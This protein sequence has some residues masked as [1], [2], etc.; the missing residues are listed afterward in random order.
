MMRA[1]SEQ[2]LDSGQPRKDGTLSTPVSTNGHHDLQTEPTEDF[3]GSL[4]WVCRV[5][6]RAAQNRLHGCMGTTPGV[7]Q[8][9]K[10]GTP[11]PIV[12]KSAHRAAGCGWFGSVA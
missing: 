6:G 2:Q 8:R 10:E 5:R 11:N 3:T 4:L 12:V 9:M 7:E 1:P